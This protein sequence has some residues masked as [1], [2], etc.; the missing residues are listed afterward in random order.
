MS[1]ESK[2]KAWSRNNYEDLML[3]DYSLIGCG[4]YRKKK[5]RD[6]SNAQGR[7]MAIDHYATDFSKEFRL[8]KKK[9][10]MFFNDE[11][12]TSKNYEL[13]HGHNH[14]LISNY[15]HK[16][17]D[18]DDAVKFSDKWW[19]DHYGI[20]TFEKFDPRRKRNGVSYVSKYKQKGILVMNNAKVTKAMERHL[21]YL[22]K[23]KNKFPGTPPP[24]DWNDYC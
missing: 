23:Q 6:V 10:C 3:D 21:N 15:Q 17:I 4:S 20:C 1:Y 9:L 11:V 14:I 5:L 22:R 19:R 16:S 2:F 8:S 18:P 24:I 7:E 12:G 13:S